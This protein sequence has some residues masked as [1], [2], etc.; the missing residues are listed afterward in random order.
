M[1]RKRKMN[2]AEKQKRRNRRD[3]RR[4]HRVAKQAATA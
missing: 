4:R 3:A 2:A 1:S